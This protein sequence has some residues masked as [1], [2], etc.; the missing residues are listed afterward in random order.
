M[1]NHFSFNPFTS[2][3]IPKA[4]IEKDSK[5][6]S[7][8][9]IDKKVPIDM[10]V[11]EMLENDHESS[12]SIHSNNTRVNLKINVLKID[13]NEQEKQIQKTQWTPTK[14]DIKRQITSNIRYIAAN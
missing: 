8:V 13:P 3:E 12:S 6:S 14:S 11:L 2:R 10:D 1:T 5:C 7:Q 4:A 9:F